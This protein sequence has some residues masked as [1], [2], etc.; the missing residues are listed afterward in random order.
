M[1]DLDIMN[2]AF[3]AKMILETVFY[4]LAIRFLWKK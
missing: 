3:I 4:I 2:V 1:V